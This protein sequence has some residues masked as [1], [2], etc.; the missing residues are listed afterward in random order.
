MTEKRERIHIL[1][2]DDDREFLS[3]LHDALKEDGYEIEMAGDTSEAMEK[4]E[5]SP[6]DL[7]LTDKNMPEPKGA[8]LIYKIK[9]KR[10]NSKIIVLTAFGDVESYLELMNMGIYDYLTKPIKMSELR[11]SIKRALKPQEVA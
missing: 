9:T 2:V 10:P 11:L 7:I 1:A 8:E 6:Y 4:V 3:L 5:A